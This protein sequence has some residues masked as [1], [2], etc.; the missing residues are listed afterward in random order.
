MPAS[1]PRDRASAPVI[2]PAEGADLADVLALLAEC[3]LPEAGLRALF[4]LGFL[5][6]RA[7]SGRLAAT[8]GVEV[9]G[10]AGLLRSV[11]VHPE[12][13][14]AGLGRALASAAVAWARSAGVR[15][16]FLLT[17]T[18]DG[19]FPRL[20]F[21]VADRGQVPKGLMRSEEFQGACPAS[22]VLM[23]RSLTDG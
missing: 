6:A 4:P 5:V 11:A 7:A 15:D 12:H 20:G 17:T 3:G 8:A 13:R 2:Q 1:D 21:A 18:A 22:A 19:Y 10:A 14:G 16:L 23:R 9:H